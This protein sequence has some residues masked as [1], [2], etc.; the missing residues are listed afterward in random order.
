MNPTLIQ[1]IKAKHEEIDEILMAPAPELIA[2]ARQER[3]AVLAKSERAYIEETKYSVGQAI[4]VGP[5]MPEPENEEERNNVFYRAITDSQKPM[6]ELLA[7]V[8]QWE[9]ENP[10]DP[11]RPSAELHQLVKV[12]MEKMFDIIFSDDQAKLDAARESFRRDFVEQGEHEFV[13]TVAQ[14]VRKFLLLIDTTLSYPIDRAT[15]DEHTL[16]RLVKMEK[17]EEHLQGV[18]DLIDE[19][20]RALSEKAATEGE[21]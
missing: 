16:A 20:H 15:L 10:L 1:Q 21:Q 17:T 3:E 11:A 14:S 4:Q 2:G 6:E 18:T 9:A 13:D 8:A 19:Y 5:T 7:L 12:S